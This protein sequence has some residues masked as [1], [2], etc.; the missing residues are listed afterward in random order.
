VSAPLAGYLPPD[1][2][3]GGRRWGFGVQLYGMRSARNWG[4]GDFSDLRRLSEI[5]AGYGADVVGVNPLH[6]LHA[7]DPEAASPYAPASRFFLNALYIDIESVPEYAGDPAL[8]AL[9]ADGEFR[10]ALDRARTA[11]HVDYATVGGCKRRALQMLHNAFRVRAPEE[12]RRRFNAFCRR[13]GR[14]LE[15]FARYEAL[16]EHFARDDG[17]T[18]GWFTWPAAYRDPGG[19]AVARFAR[20]SRVNVE[21]HKYVQ[22]VAHE[23]LVAAARVPGG[24]GLYLD[25]AVGVDPNGS[26]VWSAQGDYFLDR[27]IG[28][29]PDELGPLGQN[30]G[31]ALPRP[32]A[33]GRDNGDAFAQL[34]HHAMQY[35]TALRIDHVM[36]LLRL[37][38]IPVGRPPQ[39][40]AYLPYPFEELLQIAR[41]E[42]HAARCLT[43]GEDLG[44][45]PDG[46][47]ERM[48]REAI[49]S[50]RVLLF[51]RDGG[52][53]FVPP[54]AYP[55]LALA[56]ATTHDLPTLP[57]WVL[58][59]DLALRES[60]GLLP[61]HDAERERRGR[62]VDVTRLLEALQTSGDLDPTAVEGLHR[63]IDRR[64]G[65]PAAYLELTA[66]AYRFLAGSPA[67]LVLI[68]LDD[69]L[70][71]LDQAN[72]P[73]TDVEYPNWRR[74]SSVAVEDLGG[75][76]RVARVAGVVR[77]RVRGG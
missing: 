46:F 31:L 74:K 1:W 11:Q 5:A 70:G 3:T 65:D 61:G 51:E 62:R 37:F 41:R 76:A 27:T 9:L 73:G 44:T 15:R 66:A 23:Q 26:D 30:W 58:G 16:T 60:L 57:G 77:E 28:A 45:V 18:R 2:A 13:G 43:V 25:L 6:A 34:L 4:I 56:T 59:R 49:L 71:E 39:D 64:D 52:G 42:S 40:G 38:A 19:D 17:R 29:P 12:R 69:A 63:R 7:V 35:A 8:Q 67:G 20:R 72:V 32:E 33:L 22:F 54:F 21:R 36:S 68:Q 55:R 75:D 10:A 50:Y 48:E 24:A 53:A 14:R 47:R